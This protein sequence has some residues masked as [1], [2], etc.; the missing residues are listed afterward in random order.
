MDT[1]SEAITIYL[2]HQIAAGAQ[3]VQLFD[4]WAGCLSPADY[5]T[6][7]LP[8][9]KQIIGGIT[10]GVPVINFATGNPELLPLLR[11]DRRTVVGVDWRIS[12]DAAWQRI[13]HDCAVQGNLDPAVLL[14]EP[15]VI[16]EQIDTASRIRRRPTW[17]HLQSGTR[18]VQRNAGREC[19]CLGRDHQRFQP[20]ATKPLLNRVA[21]ASI[22]LNELFCRGQPQAIPTTAS[23]DSTDYSAW[24]ANCYHAE[25][26]PADSAD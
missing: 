10:P 25:T 8:W 20:L 14:A 9:M 2:N 16:R 11:G 22:A 1:L 12:L 7:V 13:G 3:C 19:D 5:T 15:D 24:I 18:R 6:H 21:R 4:S 26:L 17:A 23:G